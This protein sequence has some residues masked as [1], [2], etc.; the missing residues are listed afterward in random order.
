LRPADPDA[1]AAAGGDAPCRRGAGLRPRRRM[2]T[3]PAVLPAGQ[4]PE[5]GSAS[6]PRPPVAAGPQRPRGRE[7]PSRDDPSRVSTPRSS[8]RM[9]SS[10]AGRTG[11]KGRD[12]RA[13]NARAIVVPPGR[14]QH[15][16]EGLS[17]HRSAPS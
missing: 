11:I 13:P 1:R 17:R 3:T 9:G 2:A 5:S 10:G 8:S 7:R 15:A 16:S 12:N 6:P 14:A 4:T